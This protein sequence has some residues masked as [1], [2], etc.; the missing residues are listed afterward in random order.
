MPENAK[1][2][3]NRRWKIRKNSSSGAATRNVPAATTPQAD[4]AS[5]PDANEARPTVKTWL[6]GEEVA[7]NGHKNSF[8]CALIDT[9]ANATSPGRA[10]GTRTC[11]INTGI[12]APSSIAASS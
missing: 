10:K 5:A 2:E 8:Q 6:R 4:P 12:E 7:I 11:R 1:D 3:T 9:I